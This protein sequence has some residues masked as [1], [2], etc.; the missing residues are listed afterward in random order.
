MRGAKRTPHDRIDASITKTAAVRC[1]AWLGRSSATTPRRAT[2][3]V[4]SDATAGA[5]I[6]IATSPTRSTTRQREPA[7]SRRV[8]QFGKQ[9]STVATRADLDESRKR[10]QLNARARRSRRRQQRNPGRARRRP[11]PRPRC[12][13]RLSVGLTPSL[14]LRRQPDAAEIYHAPGRGRA[15]REAN[16]ARSHRRIDHKSSRRQVQGMVRPQFRDDASARNH[17]RSI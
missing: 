4:R 7:R 10:G 11:L 2:T 6:P 1:K 3:R 16:P 9:R 5:T 8:R 17:A 14:H 13:T 15:G 12:P